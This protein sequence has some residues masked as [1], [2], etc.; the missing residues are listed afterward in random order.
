MSQL[1][2]TAVLLSDIKSRGMIPT[3]Q[4]TFTEEGM[5]NLATTVLWSKVVP[6]LKSVREEFYVDR[7]DYSIVAGK[8]FYAIPER[9][10]GSMLRDLLYTSD[11]TV[12]NNSTFYSCDRLEPDRAPET[13]NYTGGFGTPSFYFVNNQVTLKPVPSSAQ[14]TLRMRYYRRPN[15]LVTVNSCAKITAVNSTTEVVVNAIPLSWTTSELFD[16]T[17]AKPHYRPY[18]IDQAVT[19]LD[20]V[21]LT[22]TFS[23]PVLDEEGNNALSVGDYIGKAT[24]TCIPEIPLEMQPLLAQRTVAKVLEALGDEQGF[25]RAE[26]M[27][28]KLEEEVLDLISP[29]IDGEPRKVVSSYRRHSYRS[30]Y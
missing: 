28:D 10:V 2:T 9:A 18:A 7:L 13:H 3:S 30:G 11:N 1:Y 24:E 25:A 23:S 15:A 29:R 22:I 26:G 17:P 8:E 4:S 21:G 20:T 16:I 6:L 5:L 19:T 27:G 12:T 14:G